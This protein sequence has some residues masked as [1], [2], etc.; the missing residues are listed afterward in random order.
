MIQLICSAIAGICRWFDRTLAMDLK[1]ASYL[2]RE[3]KLIQGS[4]TQSTLVTSFPKM[5]SCM[6][7][8][9]YT[10]PM[11]IFIH[12]Y[13]SLIYLIRVPVEKW[14][15]LL[16]FAS[17]Y[18]CVWFV[19]FYRVTFSDDSWSWILDSKNTTEIYGVIKMTTSLVENLSSI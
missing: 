3:H 15:L 2:R 17:W 18:D 11:Y 7:N 16:K 1:L 6:F 14:D 13:I 4:K 10:L 5:I 12:W 19:I 8:Q 9:I